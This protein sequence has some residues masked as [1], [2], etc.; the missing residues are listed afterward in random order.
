MNMKQWST[1]RILAVGFAFMILMGG[2]LL[3]LPIASRDGAGISFLN[4]MFTSAS[5]TCVTGLVVCDTWTQFSLF[6][7]AVILLLIQIGGLGFMTVAILFSLAVGRR[8]GLRER[9]L[10]AESVSAAQLGGVV[11]L[12]RRTLIGTAV[13]EGAG[14]VLLAV[15]FIPRFG[16]GRGIWFAVFHSVSA[17]CNAGFDLMGMQGPFSSLTH[18]FGDPLVVFTISALIITGGIGFV[19]W[20][21]L[22]DSRFRPEKFN[23]HT[24]AVLISTLTLIL[25]GTLLFLFLE[26]GGVLSKM[27]GEDRFLAAFFQSVTPRTAGFN[28]VDI[29]SLSD[30]GKLVTMLLMFIGA[31]PGGTGGGIKVTTLVVMI[32]A[33]NSSLYSREDVSVWHFRLDSET[34]RRSFCGVAVYAALTFGGTLVLCA[35]GGTLADSAFECLSAIGT[36]GLSTIDTAALPSLSRAALILLMYAGRVGSLTVFL[37]VSRS[38]GSGKLKNPFGKIIVG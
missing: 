17:F 4:A 27:N 31:A 22:I 1:K 5:A 21:D 12:V 32:A 33:V 23:L 24:R 11:R 20:N 36:V 14:A 16:L 10:L 7:Q 3:S 2:L 25:A 38:N 6:G 19:V 26:Q 30:G 18:F 28:T 8:I 37:A 35:Q 34:L 29:A 13:F 15:R 9:S